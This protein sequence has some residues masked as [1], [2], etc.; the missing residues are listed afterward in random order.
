MH[1]QAWSKNAEPGFTWF[2]IFLVDYIALQKRVRFSVYNHIRV[3]RL[4][5][6]LNHIMHRSQI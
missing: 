6:L 2:G 4:L 1:D 5:I 3:D